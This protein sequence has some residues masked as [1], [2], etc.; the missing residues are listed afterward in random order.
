MM[1]LSGVRNS[2]LM[3]ARKRLFAALAR[4]ASARASSSACCCCLRR[5]TSRNTATTSR[6]PASPASA[7]A[8]SSGRQ[9]ISIQTNST[10]GCPW[11]SASSRRTRNSTERLSAKRRGVAERRQ[12][13]GPI[14]DMDAVEQAMAVQIG[15]TRA[16]QRL[17]GRRHEQHAAV[18]AV[19]RDHVGHIVRQAADSGPLRR[20]AAR[21][22]CAP[23]P[24]RR[25]RAPPHRAL[26]KRCRARRAPRA[27][28]GWVSAKDVGCRAAPGGRRRRAPASRRWRRRDATR[29][30]PLRAARRRARSRR[31]TTMPPVEAATAV[32]SPVSASDDS[33]CALS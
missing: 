10:A 28:S 16:E 21:S 33:T 5:V 11:A 3:V 19:P 18:A 12:I 17:A 13:G 25:A 29:T 9:R 27:S 2:W 15:K 6:R 23:A 31:T 22:W 32:T 26:P 14:G 30:A 1:A 20:R 8:C 4:S 7:P 24:R